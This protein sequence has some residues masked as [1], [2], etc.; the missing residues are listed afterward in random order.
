MDHV[1]LMAANR[2][3]MFSANGHPFE[4]RKCRA[5]ILIGCLLGLS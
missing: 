4:E 1:V 5:T 2:T 3:I